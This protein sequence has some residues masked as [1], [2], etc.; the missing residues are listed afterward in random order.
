MKKYVLL[1]VTILSMVACTSDNDECKS[2][3][4]KEET[5]AYYIKY[6][7][8]APIL[9]YGRGDNTISYTNEAGVQ[10]VTTENTK[11]EITCGPVKK[12]FTA[13]LSSRTS[14]TSNSSKI[15]IK[16]FVARD[17]EP[18]V[19]KANT[20]DTENASVEYTVNK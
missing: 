10:K 11:W 8:F 16:I 15:Q 5:H 3:E 6:E 17:N 2:G 18:F 13:Q 19:L 9:V 1:L 12:G 7:V 14:V 4:V 20:E